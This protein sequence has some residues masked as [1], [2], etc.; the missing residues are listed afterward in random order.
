MLVP[1]GVPGFD[2]QARITGFPAVANIM[3]VE[4]LSPAAGIF[5]V[6]IPPESGKAE[7]AAFIFAPMS[8]PGK[9]AASKLMAFAVAGAIGSGPDVKEE[10]C[11]GA[12]C[13]GEPAWEAKLGGAKER[14]GGKGCGVPSA[15]FVMLVPFTR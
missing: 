7:Y 6:I 11:T 12:N 10:D 2:E 14:M 4:K 13:D 5:T 15:V 1:R 8:G 9:L 3:G